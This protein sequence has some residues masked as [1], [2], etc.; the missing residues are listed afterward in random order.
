MHDL[1]NLNIVRSVTESQGDNGISQC[2]ES[3][4]PVLLLARLMGQYC[5]AGW[6]LSSSSVTL[7]VCGPVGRRARGWSA[8]WSPGAWAV[9]QLTMHGGPVRLQ[10]DTLFN[11]LSISDFLLVNWFP[12]KMKF[13]S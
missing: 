10:G 6:R 3:G 1:N 11:W 9:G 7:P 5:F 13:A 8:L 4:Q 12:K 2:L